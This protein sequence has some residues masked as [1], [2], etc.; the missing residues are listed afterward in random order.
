L[1]PLETLRDPLRPLET[2]K[3]PLETLKIDL[4]LS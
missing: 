4:F 2:L 1:R 3:T